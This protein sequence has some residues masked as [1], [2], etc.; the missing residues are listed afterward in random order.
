[1]KFITIF[2]AS[3]I[4][5]FE[6]ER[7]QQ[8]ALNEEFAKLALQY[9]KNP[10]DRKLLEKMMKLGEERAGVADTLHQMEMDMLSLCNQTKRER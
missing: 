9:G 1:M 5:E 2:L 8:E 7:R 10:A 4:A 6:K 3:S